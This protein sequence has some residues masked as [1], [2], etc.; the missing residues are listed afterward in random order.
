MQAVHIIPRQHFAHRLLAN[1]EA[2]TNRIWY[3]YAPLVAANNLYM[4]GM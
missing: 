3:T 2:H 1:R 4:H